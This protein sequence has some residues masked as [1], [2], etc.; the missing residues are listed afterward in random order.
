MAEKLYDSNTSFG[1]LRT[2]PKLTGNFK[3]TL[4]SSGGIWFNS[5]DSSPDLSL[6]KYK[7]FRI[8]GKNTYAKDIYTFFDE[9]ATS[10]EIIFQVAKNTQGETQAAE[11]FAQQYDFFYAAGAST[12]ID[13]NYQEN[14]RYFQPLWINDVLPDFFVVFKVP[15][16]LSYPYPT[17][18]TTIQNG[19]QYKV[20]QEPG[21]TTPFIIE[22]WNDLTGSFQ[23]Y[24]SGEFFTGNTVFSTYEIIQG[25][26]VVTEMNELKYYDEVEN[27]QSFFNS[28]ILPYAQVVS[29]FDLRSSTPIGK[30]IRS[31]VNNPGFRQSPIDFSLQSNTFT[32][33]NGVSVSEG[34]FTQKGE[35]LNPY[36]TS[37]RSTSQIDF[38]EYITDGFFRNGVVCPNLLNL[39]FL[40]DDPDSDIY[41]INRYLGFYVS[42]N[43]LGEFK[44][45]GNFFYEFRNSPDN[46]NLPK[47]TRNNLG[48]YY[49]Q[50]PSYQSS[51]GGTRLY[52]E[53]ASGW[54][55]GSKD[56][57]VMDPQKL[58]YVTDK[59]EQFY[60][61]SRY[62]NYLEISQDFYS[63]LDNTPSYLQ[64]GPYYQRR[65]K[66]SEAYSLWS[67][68]LGYQNVTI[69][70]DGNHGFENGSFVSITGTTPQIEG[71]W[72]ITI[73]TGATGNSFEI[74]V[75]LTSGV[76]V[77]VGSTGYIAGATATYVDPAYWTNQEVSG[78]FFFGTTGSTGTKMGSVV[79]ADKKV[80]LSDFTGPDEKVGSFPGFIS[81][82]KGRAYKDITFKKSLDLDKPVTFKI[83]WPNGTRGD[84]NQK[85]DLV[86]SGDYAGTLPGWTSGSYYSTGNNNYFNWTQ[87]SVSDFAKAF[88]GAISSISTVVWDAG[89]SQGTSIIRI[90]NPGQKLN[91]QY[92]I[93]VFSDYDSFLASYQGSWNNKFPYSVGQIVIYNNNYY[94]SVSSVPQNTY[95]VNASPDISSDW[96]PYYPFPHSGY[97][98]IG[99]IDASQVF[100]SQ[101][102]EGGTDFIKNR[103]VFPLEESGNVKPGN[104]I[105]VDPG[106]GITG[107]LS[108]ISSVTRYVDSPIYDNDPLSTTGTVTGFKGF[109][110]YLVAN[111]SDNLA[112]I[113][114]GS[115][116]KFNVYGMTTVYTGVF[117][118][119]DVKDF[120]FDFWSSTY[121]ITP[122][123]E[124]HR[125]FQLTPDQEGQLVPGEKYYVKRGSISYRSSTSP[126][127]DTTVTE[128]QIFIPA[129]ATLFRDL[130]LNGKSAIV[131]PAAFTRVSYVNAVGYANPSENYGTGISSE[132][133][134]NNFPGFYGIQSINTEEVV[135]Q[136][137]KQTVFEYGKLETEYEYLEENYTVTRANKSR[138]VPYINKWVYRGGTDARGNRYRLNV[139]PA[140]S[141][142]NFS[143]GFQQDQ[144][145]P[146]YLTHEWM[147]LE[148]VPRQYPSSDI[149][150]QNNY[151]P[152]KVDL[153]RIRNSSPGEEEYFL[154]AFTVDPKNY[155]FPYT[156]TKSPVKEFFTPFYYN[157]TT[158]FYETIFR[159]V[160]ISLERRSTLPN[161]QTESEKFVSGF[162]GFEGYNFSS[163]LRVVPEDNTTIQPPVSYE[164]IENV[165][166]KCIL[167]VTY[168]VVKDYRALPLGYTGPTGSSPYLDYL[169]MYSLQS[170]KKLNIVGPTAN[171]VP[172]YSISDIKLS[173]SLDLSFSSSS[174]CNP[175]RNNGLVYI[176]PNSD[177]DTDLTEEINLFYPIGSTSGPTGVTGSLSATGGIGSFVAY[178]TP[179]QNSLYPW[180]IGRSKEVVNF[181]PTNPLNYY[182][183]IPFAPTPSP[184]LDIPVGSQS[185]YRGKPV[186]QIGGGENYFSFLTKRLS[187][188]HIANKV[189]NES[190]YIKYKTYIYNEVSGQ[191]DL[192]EN[193]FQLSFIPPTSIYKPEGI[194]PVK[195][196]SGPQTLG[197][198]QPTGYQIVSA[199]SSF[200]SDILRYSG[201]YEP[202]FRK[203][204]LFKG[205]KDDTISG[206]PNFDLSFR[207]CT[208]APEKS[209]FGLIENLNYTK[210]SLGKNILEE[211]Q[212]LPQGPVY[213]LIGQ[214]PISRKNFSVF[215]S[216]WDPGYYNLYSS[217]TDQTPVAGTRSMLEYKT[218]LGSKIMQT[219]AEV[220]TYTF[221]TLEISKTE[222]ELDPQRINAEARASLSA[223][224]SMS[225]SQ[226]NT[227]V[228]QL[229]P[230]LSG[231]DLFKLDESV[232]PE[233][234]VFW[235]YD[236]NTR[237][238]YGVIRL[239]RILRRYLL[240]SGIQSVFLRNI[241][242]EYGVG[243]PN[244]IED[245]ISSYIDQNI[246]PVYEGKEI[247]LLVLKKGTPLNPNLKLVT[248]GLVSSDKIKYGYA[249]QSNF[250]LTQRTPLT[251]QFEY[252][253]D[254]NQNYSLT[255]N[256]K[257]G[258]I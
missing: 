38:E 202:L 87:G 23:R 137:V 179:S 241:I 174:E 2:N 46:L 211:S 106:K 231:V 109:N 247:N 154:D 83:F 99:G 213:P 180:P 32:Y 245:D 204:I 173:S 86:T 81:G 37:S 49:N 195:S 97:L 188:S 116:S 51:T 60:S 206:S 67:P 7:K 131:L 13:K 232:Y 248:G 191:T 145:N 56:V 127:V 107:G 117:S 198:N 101:I 88:N 119:F 190:P 103:V 162:R 124:F 6:Q 15:D 157:S 135:D 144:P 208:F 70:T 113:S 139:S 136:N 77:V 214:T 43:D 212:N 199:G 238:V 96:T 27:V 156:N 80:N 138:I 163:I 150:Y 243:N 143:P 58:Y 33:Y 151:L 40:F 226:S 207:N 8:T 237:I 24:F 25:S 47:P 9:G 72:E 255:F 105:Q 219:P 76:G 167:F 59:F 182:F 251:Y 21:T 233:V 12:L 122:T 186:V 148:E 146:D 19:V 50:S 216:T 115:D 223:I 166:Q 196:Y 209:G 205:D 177:Y 250:S 90:K 65:S 45:N 110:E 120:N 178:I 227:G 84:L 158:G 28:K 142:T 239:D 218:F 20:I 130:K 14:F 48:Y 225:T 30:Y 34:V 133:D 201:G 89:S 61:L 79:I 160:K 102:F 168:A 249:S 94:E 44:L 221:I 242:S 64:F 93:S 68:D 256:F 164:V 52:Y 222:G 235:Q 217:S 128:G 100:S 141:P 104:W 123:Q 257:T 16:P 118:F 159:G 85:Y 71:T 187:L 224:Q 10:K 176:V 189:N 184:V 175:S 98:E 153:D 215:L 253:L 165:T 82:E 192:I 55:P 36:L 111:L 125:Y 1:V 181:G 11:T 240:N 66:V 230:A 244:S 161:P 132:Q 134:L 193:Y 53:G 170:K 126:L 78:G 183:E 95:G 92:S 62:E 91:P 236:P 22:Y 200:P 185:A 54:I 194:V 31:I 121:G 29:T 42:R 114:L 39:E 3:I 152:Y 169:L 129:F 140:F 252:T 258:K 112:V 203:V 254:P 73:P 57:N 172:L 69:I 246:V 197:Q 5:M 63:F 171:G 75:I 210:V 155:P 220:T 229:G 234:E 108:L 17:N 18:T 35:I 149:P 4:D 26:G 228:G 41:T 147:I 74:P